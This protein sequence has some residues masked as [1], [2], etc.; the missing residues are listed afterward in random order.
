MPIGGARDFTRRN[1]EINDYKFNCK[2]QNFSCNG[3]M[4]LQTL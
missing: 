1:L 2:R 3:H 4:W